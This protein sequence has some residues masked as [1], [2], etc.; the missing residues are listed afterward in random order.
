MKFSASIYEGSMYSK[1]LGGEKMVGFDEEDKMLELLGYLLSSE[2]V[3]LVVDEV[4]NEVRVKE[5]CCW[6]ES[7]IAIL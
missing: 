6:R 7:Q 5:F 2:L 4:K 1:L 3:I